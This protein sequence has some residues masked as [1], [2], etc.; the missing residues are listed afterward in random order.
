MSPTDP[1][2]FPLWFVLSVSC[3]RN[4]CLS[5]HHKDILLLFYS[6]GSTAL[7]LMFESV[8]YVELTLCYMTQWCAIWYTVWYDIV[9]KFSFFSH[10][11][12]R[13]FFQ[14]HLLKRSFFLPS[15]YLPSTFA[16]SHLTTMCGS[17]CELYV[18]I[19]WFICLFLCQYHTLLITVEL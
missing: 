2:F 1:F 14:N 4:I 8:T 6:R 12:C 19:R 5:Q 16:K 7:T 13:K 11:Y 17:V 18:L 15:K 3:V 9:V 10:G